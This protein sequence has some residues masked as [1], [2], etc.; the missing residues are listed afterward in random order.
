MR[1]RRLQTAAFVLPGQ[2]ENSLSLAWDMAAYVPGASE[3]GRAS[4]PMPLRTLDGMSFDGGVTL[5]KL[6]GTY[7]F[8]HTHDHLTMEGR[9]LARS[10]PIGEYLKNPDFMEE[11]KKEEEPPEYMAP[12]TPSDRPNTPGEWSSTLEA[13]SVA[14]PALSLASRR[15][16]SRPSVKTR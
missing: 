8:A 6:G 15:T 13:A 3:T 7:P 9:D 10:T 5:K 14:M 16:I 12:E 2:P 4:M 1:S 11:K